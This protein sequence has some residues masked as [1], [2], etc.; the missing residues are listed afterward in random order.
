MR[1]GDGEKVQDSWHQWTAMWRECMEAE[2]KPVD[3]LAQLWRVLPKLPCRLGTLARL[4]HYEGAPPGAT[5]RSLQR[6]DDLF[7]ICTKAVATFLLDKGGSVADAV[8]GMVNSLNYMALYAN[9]TAFPDHFE[10]RDL[11]QAQRACVMHLADLV[12]HLG[13]SDVV[14]PSF[15]ESSQALAGARFDY[16]GDPV[17]PLEDL[18]AEKVIAAWPKIGEAAIQDAV[19]FVPP[20]IRKC[21]L[22]PSMCLKHLHE[23]P[24]QPT[25]SKVRASS[26]EWEKIVAAGHARGLMVMVEPED[27]FKDANGHPVLNGAGGVKKL[28]TV[29]GE[30]K[31]LQRFISNLIP[32]NMFQEH[33]PGDDYL[34]PY[35]G[36]LTLLEQED[37]EIWFVDSEDFTSCFNLFRLPPCWNRFMAFGKLVDAKVFGG[38][39]G[40]LVYPAM[41][42]LPMGWLSS[43]AVIQ[44]I[45]RTL[46]FSEAGVPET[47]EIAKT[48]PI[49]P[50][51]DLT[52]IYLD[53][54]DQLRRLDRGCQG[55]LQE[56]AS[57]RHQAFLKVCREKGLPLNKAKS[58]VSSTQGTLQGG[59][60]DGTKGR[61]GLARDK[62]ADLI[63]LGGALLGQKQWGEFLLRHFVGKATF[64][65]C[66]RRPL[67]S[68]FQEIF[69]E[70]QAQANGKRSER[71]PFL[72]VEEVA[73]VM[74]LVPFMVTNLKAPI[75]GEIAVTDAS[76]SGGGAAVATEFRRPPNSVDV[77]VDRCYECGH[78]LGQ[79][80]RYPCP[81]ECG[82]VF[83][84]LACVMEHREVDHDAHHECPRRAWR[85]PRF[86]E[87]FAGKRAPLS[88]AVA[89]MGHIEVQEPFDLHF[90]HN[91]FTE[92]GRSKL[93]SLCDDEFLEAEHWAPECRLFSKARG[94]P[95]VLSSGRRIAGPQP[96]RD[97]KH[98][99][100]FPWL[101]S[102]MKAKVR[103]SN[104]MALKALKRGH[105]AKGRR[106]WTMEHPYGSWVWEFQLVQTLEDDPAFAH[107]VGSCCC[108]GGS[109][110]KWFSFFGNVSTMP[111]YLHKECPGH[112]GLQA[113]EVHE[114]ADGSLQ[115]DT[116]EEAEYPW[117]LC[118]A[119]A[120][121]LRRQI[122]LDGTFENMVLKERERYYKDQMGQATSRLGSA[123]V[124][125]AVA[126]LLARMESAMV[127]GQERGHLRSLLRSAS[128]RGTDVRFTVELGEGIEPQVHE[129]PYLAMRWHWK[130][131]LAFPWKHPAH[132][133]ELE[134]NTVAVFLKRRARTSDKHRAKFFLVLDSMVTRGCLSKGRSSSRRLNQ[135]LRKCAAHLLGTDGYLFPLW[136]I[137]AW[138]FADKPSRMH[139]AQA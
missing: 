94:K 57:R 5:P 72:V 116:A 91:I 12:E 2:T 96:V 9:G 114:Q 117:E 128:Y 65:M 10:E 44:A 48:K 18:V 88:H 92:E 59:E 66:F 19:D 105:A 135:V 31:V 61:Y 68:I 53:S 70:I 27:V 131:I 83:C 122:D 130:T 21:L 69:H 49:P 11:T 35:L 33:I 60:L 55:A 38:P 50:D 79:A 109:R 30:T 133:N 20:Y 32:S 113:Y 26:E 73:L 139:E 138:N 1:R 80:D 99:M 51:D 17:V 97:H 54:F 84:S 71:P 6:G 62:M 85:P 90:G 7:P 39:P 95:I 14:T 40:K 118:R 22:N 119:Y 121:A 36:Q 78:R 108:F 111:D 125:D 87:R 15:G 4:S 115:F 37:S 76:P 110:T 46:V 112:P 28:K 106:Y 74:S 127:A 45:V 86:G 41:S 101:S 107:A 77:D 137:S 3:L 56:G 100:G 124:A 52:V 64:G 82:G 102:E 134:L 104:S 24:S 43:V 98:L 120:Q 126:A 63:G 93:Q 129:I 13:E 89:M 123:F 23:W 136:T 103:Q 29:G 16:A 75:D 34:L 8:N 42:V 25:A 47:S 67:L 58:L 132:M 81:A